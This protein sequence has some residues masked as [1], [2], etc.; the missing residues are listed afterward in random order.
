MKKKFGTLL[1]T[2]SLL[3][4]VANVVSAADVAP[5][6][7]EQVVTKFYD[8][9]KELN[10]KDYLEYSKDLAFDSKE[11]Q[12]EQIEKLFSNFGKNSRLVNYEIKKMEKI[13][14]VEYIATVSQE[15]DDLG[16]IPAY[17][18]PVIQEDGKWVVVLE[19]ITYEEKSNNKQELTIANTSNKIA[20]NDKFIV[21]KPNLGK[22]IFDIQPQEKSAIISPMAT[23]IK[24]YSFRPLGSYENRRS[25]GIFQAPYNTGTTIQGWQ[26][27]TGSNQAYVV[28]QLDRV[29]SSGGYTKV[30]AI[31]VFGDSKET[32]GNTW[33]YNAF[34][35][36]PTSVDLSLQVT[37]Q[38]PDPVNLAG[39]IYN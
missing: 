11:E 18:I 3:F 36:V 14:D 35:N 16:Q 21:T 2:A 26:T 25:A 38:Y 15:F 10:A 7:P 37:N 39:N 27:S 24:Y 34:N 33:F 4:G 5:P 12:K 8:A 32:A 28:Y 29:T 20:E 9:A 1:L 31:S 13:S 17:D 6:S 19:N 23:S 22:D 30:S